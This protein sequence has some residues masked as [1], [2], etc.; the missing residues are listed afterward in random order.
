MNENLE[1]RET[2]NFVLSEIVSARWLHYRF[3]SELL[4]L[5]EY[6]ADPRIVLLWYKVQTKVPKD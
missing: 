4:Q 2:V 6:E 5:I 1:R 3:I